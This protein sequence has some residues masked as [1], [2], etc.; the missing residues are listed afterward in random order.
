[1]A[2]PMVRSGIQVSI[3]KRFQTIRVG[4]LPVRISFK[5]LGRLVVFTGAD[6]GV[7]FF[8]FKG[9]SS[10]SRLKKIYKNYYNEGISIWQVKKQE[11]GG[12]CVGFASVYWTQ[13]VL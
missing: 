4:I 2:G 8:I 13:D 1:M 5:R 7:C 9:Y 6:A 12:G 11:R 3:N 10:L